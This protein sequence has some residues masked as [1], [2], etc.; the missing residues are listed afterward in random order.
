M[1]TILYDDGVYDEN[2]SKARWELDENQ[3]RGGQAL[4][5]ES[6]D[7]LEVIRNEARRFFCSGSV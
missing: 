7:K 3:G 1:H 2:L 6:R 4:S 5:Q